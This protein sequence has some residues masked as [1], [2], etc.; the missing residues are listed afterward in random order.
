MDRGAW[1][2]IVYGVIRVGHNSVTEPPHDEAE[3]GYGPQSGTP[4][5]HQL[6]NIPRNEKEAQFLWT[7]GRTGGDTEKKSS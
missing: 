5:I 1:Q 4:H 2:A 6:S 7:K 3:L